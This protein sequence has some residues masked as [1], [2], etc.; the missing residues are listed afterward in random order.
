[1]VNLELYKVFYTVAKCRSI[2]KAAAELYISQPA[3][4]QAVKQL[5]TELGGKLFNRVSRG[6]ELTEPGGRQMFETVEKVL[7]MLSDAEKNFSDVK[8]IAKGS[9]RIAASDN[10]INY[11][12][13][14]YIKEFKYKYK[15]VRLYFYNGTSKECVELVKSGKADVG[16]VNLPFEEG[17]VEFAGKTGRIHDI[18]VASDKFSALFD[19]I[20]ELKN[21]SAYPL[22]FL[23]GKTATRKRID[24]YASLNGVKFEPDMELG[25]VELLVNMALE[26]MGVACVP[27]EYVVKELESGALTALDVTPSFPVREVGVICGKDRADSFVVNEFLNMFKNRE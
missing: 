14:D 25:S 21:M 16:F 19:K 22:L 2:T 18:F 4:S 7:N 24:E 10:V 5:E 6:M 17:A 9:V 23:D 13:L 12:L 11:F 27:E 1:M 26:G 3:V 15:N 20:I 8:R